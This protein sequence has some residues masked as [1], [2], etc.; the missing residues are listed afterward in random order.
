MPACSGSLNLCAIHT[1]PTSQQ[2]LLINMWQGARQHCRRM[3]IQ[4]DI[5]AD[6]QTVGA[7]SH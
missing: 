3:N 4:A 5:L 7:L 6:F 2:I 1:R